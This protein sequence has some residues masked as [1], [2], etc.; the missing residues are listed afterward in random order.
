MADL[1]FPKR[2]AYQPE[3]FRALRWG[4]N[5]EIVRDYLV[6]TA[7]D[8]SQEMNEYPQLFDPLQYERKRWP[9]RLAPTPEEAARRM[10]MYD[11]H[12]AG[13]SIYEV[14]GMFKGEYEERSQV[15][16]IIF[17]LESKHQAAAKAAGCYDVLEA[18]MRWVMAE[19]MR[20]DHILPWSAGEKRR[21]TRLHGSWPHYKRVFLNN[22]YEPITKEVKQWVDDTGL[23]V[24]GYLVRRFWREV[25]EQQMNEEE[26]WT[27]S[28]FNV[29][30][31]I[32][33]KA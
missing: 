29:N 18:L 3:I 33:K 20:L 13:W 2:V 11:H 12:F 6:S 10:G 32:V 21:F 19:H 24:F 15:L 5:E 9:G 1:L 31:N 26:I 4:L 7:A 23:F 25:L 27:V 14:D 16:R 30:L 8:L 22:Y 28:W 17:K